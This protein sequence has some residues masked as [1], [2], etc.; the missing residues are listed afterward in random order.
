MNEIPLSLV[1]QMDHQAISAIDIRIVVDDPEWQALR[2]SFLG[3]WKAS[4]ST[5]VNQLCSYLL[6]GLGDPYR[7]R[8][9]HNY[10][11]GSAFRLGVISHPEID[12]LRELV[13]EVRNVNP[14]PKCQ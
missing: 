3:T 8:R 1:P 12:R 13:R 5:N 4:P 9:V 11:T 2:K 10:L 7:W 6:K 14:R